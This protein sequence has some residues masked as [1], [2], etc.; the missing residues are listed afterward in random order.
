MQNSK[1]GQWG[2]CGISFILV[3]LISQKAVYWILFITL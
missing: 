1:L 3:I 2:L